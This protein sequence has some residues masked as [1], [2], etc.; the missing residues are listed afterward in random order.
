MI[1]SPRSTS[2]Q[3]CHLGQKIRVLCVSSFPPGP[4]IMPRFGVR[5][6]SV[7]LASSH[8]VVATLGDASTACVPDCVVAYNQIRPGLETQAI[9]LGLTLLVIVA[10][11]IGHDVFGRLDLASLSVA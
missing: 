9:S 8:G 3:G 5:P 10:P 1:P 11:I 4:A 7:V 2:A 6:L